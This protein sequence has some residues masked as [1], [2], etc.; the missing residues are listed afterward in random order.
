MEKNMVCMNIPLLIRILEETR[1]NV[2]SDAELHFLVDQ[3]LQE[4]EVKGKTLTMD[5]YA[6]ITQYKVRFQ[7]FSDEIV[8]TG[9][10]D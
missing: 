10:E 7:Y 9:K 4:Q 2:G 6:A 1:E 5:D 3:I 8:E